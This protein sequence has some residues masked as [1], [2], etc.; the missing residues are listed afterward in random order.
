MKKIL[1][2]ASTVSHI[3]N[4]HRDYIS[5]LVE[6]GC[7]VKVLARGE[8]AD[9]D[10]PFE[11]SIMSPKNLV[12]IRKIRRILSENRFDCVILNTSLAAF[13]V[14]AAARGKDRPKIINTVHG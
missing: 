6:S 12:C 9:F 1:Y 7:E 5:A 8:E 13:C 3:N 2:C 14:R 11:K 10:I 4:F